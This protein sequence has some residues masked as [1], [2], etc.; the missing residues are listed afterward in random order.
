MSNLFVLKCK[1]EAT[2]ENIVSTIRQ[3]QSQR[4]ITMEDAALATVDTNGK[5]KIRQAHDLVGAGAMG[6]AFWGM[7][8][9]LLFLSPLLGAAI[10][11]GAGALVGKMSDV[12]I[13][14]NFIKQVGNAIHPGE[15]ALFLLTRNEVADKVLPALRQHQFE[16]IQTSLSAEDEAR[17]HEMLGP[18]VPAQA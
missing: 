10:G 3:L 5:P 7:L 6:G 13:D 15:A 2:A 16:V 14:D 9:G 4:L 12:G 18:A 8:V 11:A 17:L 1:D